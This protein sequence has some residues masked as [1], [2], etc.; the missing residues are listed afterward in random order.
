MLANSSAFILKRLRYPVN[1]LADILGTARTLLMD[2]ILQL[3]N[4]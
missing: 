2:F 1:S 3:L 4:K